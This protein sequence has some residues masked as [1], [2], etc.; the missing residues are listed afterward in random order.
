MR[1]RRPAR[2][3]MI[4][5]LTKDSSPMLLRTRPSRA[6]TRTPG[7]FSAAAVRRKPAAEPAPPLSRDMPAMWPSVL[8]SAPPVS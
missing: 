5:S 7:I 6:M 8:R 2:E 1:T 3:R 4:S